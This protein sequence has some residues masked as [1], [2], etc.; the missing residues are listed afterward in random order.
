MNLGILIVDDEQ[1]IRSA[2][3]GL[4]EDEGYLVT[5][6]SSGEEA[7]AKLR[8]LSFACVLLDIW[9]PG[10]DGLETLT[11]I[12]QIDDA[13]P[14]IMMSGHATI[15]TAV[16]ATRQ[17]AFDFLEKPLSSDK[18]LIL[19]RNAIEKYRLQRQ[20]RVLREHESQRAHEL[21]G[22]HPS[23]EAVRQRI[24]KLA[25]S[26]H[27]VLLL[28]EHGAGKT[29]AARMLHHL[30]GRDANAW[31]ELNMAAIPSGRFDAVLLGVEQ[32][33]DSSQGKLEI[34]QGGALYLDELAELDCEAQALLHRLLDARHFTPLGGSRRI[35]FDV[36]FI[37]ASSQPL[38]ALKEHLREDLFALLSREV[39]TLPPLNERREDIPMLLEHLARSVAIDLGVRDP[40]RFE[41]DALE[42]LTSYRWPGNLREMRNYIERCQILHANEAL[43]GRGFSKDNL[44]PVIVGEGGGSVPP[45]RDSDGLSFAAA[46][47]HF[48]AEFLRRNLVQHDWNISRTA[49]AIG[50]E[51]SQLHRKMRALGITRGASS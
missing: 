36:R 14:V 49:S 30:S 41:E 18:L 27:P 47:E 42:V 21:I 51:R 50:M 37:C 10:I 15:D 23:I 7:I 13:L 12:R 25:S 22:E 32:G 19:V 46:K 17:G 31:S 45:A 5:V 28:G 9:M 35:R 40:V 6:A 24:A 4:F 3:Q 34:A 8:K 43:P 1:A 38:A 48:E 33:E 44:P 2:L 11:R 16:R 29:L 39:V 20:N 26:R